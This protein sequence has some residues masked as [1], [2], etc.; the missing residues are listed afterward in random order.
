M[1]QFYDYNGHLVTMSFHQG[2]LSNEP[3]HVLIIC[4]YEDSWL[5]TNHPKRGLEFPGGKVEKLETSEEAAV[6]EV[7]EETG[8]KV[9]Q[10]I[11]IGEYIVEDQ[12]AKSSFA[13][14]IYFAEIKELVVKED[15]QETLG[16]TMLKEL[17]GD[18]CNQGG[19]SFIMKDQVV[20]LALK[21]ISEQGI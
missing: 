20:P 14:V 2:S 13:K 3:G 9:D 6:R 21:R 8:G 4:R 5:L 1:K 18:V 17:S 15:Y 12:K 19:F 11:Y 7:Y 10:L 16:P